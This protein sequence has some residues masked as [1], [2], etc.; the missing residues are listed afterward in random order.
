MK[1][2]SIL[3]AL[4]IAF[5]GVTVAVAQSQPSTD[6]KL[7]YTQPLSVSAIRDV[8]Q[9]LHGLGLYKG[10]IDGNWGADSA[11]ALKQFQQSKGLQATGQLNEAT[12]KTLN[13]NLARLLGV[14]QPPDSNNA[15]N[16]QGAMQG[17]AQNNSSGSQGA[18]LS[19]STIQAVQERLR[20]L[21][22]DVGAAD[23]IWGADTQKALTKF[24]Q[25][26]S[27]QANGQLNPAT[28]NALG[29][30]ANT[31]LMPNNQQ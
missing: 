7:T 8:Q 25:G 18:D 28:I 30:N 21:N 29:L 5:S 13:L 4:A 26:H 24:Q 14:K 6:A 10:N 12:A 15:G 19:R 2:Q 11:S 20:K 31:L 23:G 27:L 3:L 16:N 17:S 1:I 9:I 22:Y